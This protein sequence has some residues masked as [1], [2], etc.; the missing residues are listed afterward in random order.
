MPPVHPPFFSPSLFFLHPHFCLAALKPHPGDS[1]TGSSLL[2]RQQHPTCGP[3]DKLPPSLLPSWRGS[4]HV[5]RL[6]WSRCC[7]AGLRVAWW[8]AELRLWT[9]VLWGRGRAKL[10]E[11][12]AV[13]LACGWRGGVQHPCCHAHRLANPHRFTCPHRP[14]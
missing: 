6:G 2:C 7:A 11:E 10:R 3:P 14:A 4:S 12:H 8:R 1:L 5:V 9:K 13:L